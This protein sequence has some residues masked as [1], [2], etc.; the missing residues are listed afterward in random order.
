[1]EIKTILFWLL[2][3]AMA[4]PSV[5]FG[6]TKLVGLADKVALFKRFGYPIW[7]M[8]LVGLGE[9]AAGIGL[10]FAQTRLLAIGALALIL[11]GAIGSHV[12][13]K[14]PSKEVM[15][16]VFVFIHLIVIFIFT[17]F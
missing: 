15:S 12:R 4:A 8:K 7:F 3:I 16:P 11:I 2:L 1:M 10:L 9:V 17:L 13:A 14:D 5:Y 6:Y